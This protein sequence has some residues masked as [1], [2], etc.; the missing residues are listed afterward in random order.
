MSLHALI[1]SDIRAFGGEYDPR[2]LAFWLFLAKQLFFHSALFGVFWHRYGHWVFRDCPIPVWRHLHAVNYL[3]W[4]PLVR[5]TTGVDI[6]YG[7]QIGPGLVLV[8]GHQVI[9]EITAGKNLFVHD[10]ALVG[11]VEGQYPTLGNDVTLGA[12]AVVIG[13]IHLGDGCRVGAAAVV[14]KDVPAGATAV[15]NSARIIVKL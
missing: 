3:L 6:S 7:A 1:W 8:H 2:K 4:L 13:G 15:G 11:A 9:G 5:T 12:R 10:G 14:V